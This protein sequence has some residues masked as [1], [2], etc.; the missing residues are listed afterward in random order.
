M[1]GLCFSQT[2][3]FEIHT[4][5]SGNFVTLLR[6]FEEALKAQH[7]LSR[8]KSHKYATRKTE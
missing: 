5:N 8:V 7:E 4:R 2:S 3:S 1:K 6:K